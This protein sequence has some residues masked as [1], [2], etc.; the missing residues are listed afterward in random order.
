[1]SLRLGLTVA[2]YASGSFSVISLLSVLILMAFKIVGAFLGLPFALKSFSQMMPLCL[3]LF[4]ISSGSY[5]FARGRHPRVLFFIARLPY[6]LRF[7]VLMLQELFTFL[8]LL[9]LTAS[10]A[11]YALKVSSNSL[12]VLPAFLIAV[13]SVL[14][15]LCLTM[16]YVCI[17]HL[18][19][20]W[21]YRREV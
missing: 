10:E 14:S 5:A 4:A 9:T 19:F 20:L 2:R 7:P 15:L 13:E 12:L 6:F 21:K 17:G 11:L 3:L 1:M 18:A 16:L 8:V